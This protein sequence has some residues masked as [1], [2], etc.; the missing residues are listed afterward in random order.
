MSRKQMRY[1]IHGA[2]NQANIP[3]VSITYKLIGKD[4]INAI[5][6][7]YFLFMNEE[8]IAKHAG[9]HNVTNV[10]VAISSEPERV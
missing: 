2:I 7:R 6:M 8:T 5:N 3:G 4:Q 1:E 10:V 9:R